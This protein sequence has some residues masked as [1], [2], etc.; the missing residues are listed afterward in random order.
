MAAALTTPGAKVIVTSPT[1]RQSNELL[2]DKVIPLLD[3]LGWP[4]PARRRAAQTLELAN[5]AR[6]ISLPGVPATVRSYSSV[7]LLIIDEAA[8]TR[9]ELYHAITPVLA[10]SRGRLVAVSTPFGERG[11]FHREWAG[12]GADWGRFQVRADQC[13]RLPA[14]FLAREKVSKGPRW[15][16]QEYLTSFEAVVG[17][18]FSPEDIAAAFEA[19]DEVEPLWLPG[20]A[21]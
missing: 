1:Q 11:W 4:V 12:G 15:Y 9:D 5:G 21:A 7:T 10:V 8:Y 18:V 13:P 14:D 16:A 2:R 3:A 20:P 17:G 6:V 19:R